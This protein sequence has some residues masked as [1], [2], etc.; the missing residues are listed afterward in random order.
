M[1]ISA[2]HIYSFRTGLCAVYVSNTHVA[3]RISTLSCMIFRPMDARLFCCTNRR[4][5]VVYA[6]LTAITT[7]CTFIGILCNHY[8]VAATT[9]CPALIVVTAVICPRHC[10]LSISYGNDFDNF[11]YVLILQI[12]LYNYPYGCMLNSLPFLNRPKVYLFVSNY[13]SK[14]LPSS[15]TDSH[16]FSIQVMSH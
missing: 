11:I 9:I 8:S 16:T 4:V 1:R 12:I 13:C 3:Q 6:W 15:T 2:I 10:Q 14:Y 7:E 5:R